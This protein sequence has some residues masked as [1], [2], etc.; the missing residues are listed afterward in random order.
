M[1]FHLIRIDPNPEIGGRV[2]AFDLQFLLEVLTQ[3]ANVAVIILI[4][5]W[6]LYKPMLQFMDKRKDRI[7]DEI[8]QAAANLRQSEETRATY[9]EKLAGINSERDEILD[10]ARK[11]A[12]EREAEII[13]GANNEA[14]LILQRAQREVE[15]EWQKSRDDMRTQIIQVSSLLAEQLVSKTLDDATKDKLLNQA[16]SELG[17]AAWKN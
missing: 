6:L 17:D 9:N 13:A 8:E 4:L 7:R 16:I 5:A 14:D 1:Y 3:W 12:R 15:L 10:T 2:L 11:S